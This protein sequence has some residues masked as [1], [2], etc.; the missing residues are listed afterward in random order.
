MLPRRLPA[1]ART[2]LHPEP[3]VE[4]RIYEASNGRVTVYESCATATN[5]YLAMPTRAW[6]EAGRSYGGGMRGMEPGELADLPI[7]LGS[8]ALATA[9]G[10]L[11]PRL[12]PFSP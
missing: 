12:A 4:G 3:E 11:E 7:D 6:V 8:G 10:C 5:A 2:R 9:L 1:D